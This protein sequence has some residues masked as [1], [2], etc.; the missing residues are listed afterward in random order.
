MLDVLG[1]GGVEDEGEGGGGGRSHQSRRR[2]SIFQRGS[3]RRDPINLSFNDRY[4]KCNWISRNYLTLI[5]IILSGGNREN[6]FGNHFYWSI[7]SF[8]FE[9]SFLK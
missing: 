2:L 6:S 5:S 1:G 8:N 3:E 4:I 9:L 7:W